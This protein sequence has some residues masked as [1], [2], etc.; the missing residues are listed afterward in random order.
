MVTVIPAPTSSPSIS[1]S[2]PSPPNSRSFPAPRAIP[3]SAPASRLIEMRSPPAVSP[4]PM[5]VWLALTILSVLP[6]T[7]L[8]ARARASQGDL[9]APPRSGAVR[10]PPEAAFEPVVATPS[11]KNIV[12][13]PADHAIVETSSADDFATV[14]SIDHCHHYKNFIVSMF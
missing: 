2:N 8:K 12:P 11:Q 14:R 3:V 9:D 5:S 4:R 7:D 13:K 6:S 1:R 10:D